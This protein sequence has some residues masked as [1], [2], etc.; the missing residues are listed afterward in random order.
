MKENFWTK[1]L[2]KLVENLL[3]IKVWVLFALLSVSTKLLLLG[4]MTGTEWCAVN[5]GAIS[6]ICAMREAFK[7][8]KVKSEDDTKDLMV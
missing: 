4:L 7:I 1:A 6:T 3:S 8:S 2:Q 5:G